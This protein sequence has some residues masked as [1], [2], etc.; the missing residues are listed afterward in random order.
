MKRLFC[1]L[2]ALAMGTEVLPLRGMA[3]AD[4]LLRFQ[5]D[6]TSG[7][8]I[9]TASYQG[10]DYVMGGARE[11]GGYLALTAARSFTT[12]LYPGEEYESHDSYVELWA[13]QGPNLFQV[14]EGEDFTFCLQAENGLWLK[15][16]D[17]TLRCTEIGEAPFFWES[18]YFVDDS[19]VSALNVDKALFLV[20]HVGEGTPYFT[21]ADALG[22]ADL[23]C[24]LAAQTECS[25][26]N[27]MTHHA[28]VAPTCVKSGSLEYW[29]CS[30][31]E[32]AGRAYRFYDEE[33][34]NPFWDDSEIVLPATGHIDD[35]AD[36]VCDVCGNGM[37]VFTRVTL[38]SQIQAGQTYLLA[39]EV[40]ES[41]YLLARPDENDLYSTTMRATESVTPDKDGALRYSD[42]RSA[43]ALMFRLDISGGKGGKS[44]DPNLIG[45][46]NL[47]G[48]ISDDG[49]LE[50]DAGYGF[51]YNMGSGYG[52]R[53][54]LDAPPTPTLLIPR[55]MSDFGPQFY[56]RAFAPE[57]APFFSTLP[58]YDEDGE[59]LELDP[60]T[61]EYPV[62]LY[63]LNAEEVDSWDYG[64]V[65]QGETELDFSAV[66]DKPGYSAEIAAQSSVTGLA[67]AVTDGT[68]RAKIEDFREKTGSTASN[69]TLTA[70][71][72][73]TADGFEASNAATGKTLRYSISHHLRVEDNSAEPITY[74]L[75]PG[76]LQDDGVCY[77]LVL[78]SWYD[79]AQVM[80]TDEFIMGGS[81][82]LTHGETYYRKTSDPFFGEG[83]LT[84]AS[85]T[86]ADGQNAL[87]CPVLPVAVQLNETAVVEPHEHCTD[88]SDEERDAHYV[89]RQDGHY[90]EC[91][92]CDEPQFIHPHFYNLTDCDY[93]FTDTN[94]GEYVYHCSFCYER[95]PEFYEKRETIDTADW[96]WVNIVDQNGAPVPQFLSKK[97]YCYD[98]R[99]KNDV[100]VIYSVEWFKGTQHL[101]EKDVAD[102]EYADGCAALH[103]R[104]DVLSEEVAAAPLN[105]VIS[106]TSEAQLL[107]KVDSQLRFDDVTL[108][109]AIHVDVTKRSGRAITITGRLPEEMTDWEHIN[110]TL[111]TT[112]PELTYY[113]D[114]QFEDDGSFTITAP[115]AYSELTISCTTPIN[116]I[117]VNRFLFL[118]NA[119]SLGGYGSESKLI[120]LGVLDFANHNV[121]SS[122]SFTVEDEVAALVARSAYLGG[123]YSLTNE[124]TGE[125]WTSVRKSCP[126]GQD[127][128]AE[129]GAF[130]F[131]LSLEGDYAD[132]FAVG[133]TVVL[134]C[135]LRDRAYRMDPFRFTLEEIGNGEGNQDIGTPDFYRLPMLYIDKSSVDRVLQVRYLWWSLLFDGEGRLLGDQYLANSYCLE[136]GSYTY[137]AYA[138][139]RFIDLVDSPNALEMMRVPTTGYYRQTFTVRRNDIVTVTPQFTDIDPYQNVTVT[140]TL[141]E[142]LRTGESVPVYISY[143]GFDADYV[144]LVGSYAMTVTVRSHTVNEY[145][146]RCPLVRVGGC[147]AT[148]NNAAPLSETELDYAKGGYHYR[149]VAITANAT[150]GTICVY[151]RPDGNSLYITAESSAANTDYNSHSAFVL[152]I[153]ANDV[154][155]QAPPAFTS[156]PDGEL[157]FL[158]SLPRDGT[159][160]VA[161]AFVDGQETDAKTVN[162]AGLGV[163]TLHYTLGH[164]GV[165]THYHDLRLEIYTA[166]CDESGNWLPD[167]LACLW[168][169]QTYYVAVNV[170]TAVPQPS[171]LTV[172]TRLGDGSNLQTRIDLKSS[173]NRQHSITFYPQQF[174]EDGTLNE[175]L[176]YD[177]RLALD[178]AHNLAEGE[179][180]VLMTVYCGEQHAEPTLYQV[181]LL[182]NEN[183]GT[184]DGTLH[185]DADTIRLDDLPF[186]YSFFF[187]GP[188]PEQDSSSA[189]AQAAEAIERRAQSLTVDEPLPVP[190]L[191]DLDA[192]ETLLASDPDMEEWEKEIMRLDA[193]YQNNLHDCWLELQEFTAAL[194]AEC[195]SRFDTLPDFS[196]SGTT[197]G[198]ELLGSTV[199]EVT[200]AELGYQKAETPS[201][202]YY[203]LLDI[204]KGRQSVVE[205]SS[206]PSR[207]IH[208]WSGTSP[209][210][211]GTPLARGNAAETSEALRTAS[212]TLLFSSA[213]DVDEAE[214]ELASYYEADFV[215]AV[216]SFL[217][218]RNDTLEKL[219]TIVFKITDPAVV[220]SQNASGAK[221]EALG[222][223]VEA[224]EAEMKRK[225]M[226]LLDLDRE[227]A[228]TKEKFYQKYPTWRPS[229]KTAIVP[230]VEAENA[231]SDYVKARARVFEQLGEARKVEAS[232]RADQVTIG[233]LKNSEAL[234]TRINEILKAGSEVKKDLKTLAKAA[235]PY[236]ATGLSAVCMVL[237]VESYLNAH[238]DTQIA[239]RAGAANR[240]V[241]DEMRQ[242]MEDALQDPC[243]KH[244]WLA[245]L[246]YDDC[247][248]AYEDYCAASFR[249][250]HASYIRTACM[251][252]MIIADIIAL[253]AAIGNAPS[254]TAAGAFVVV[255]NSL[256]LTATTAY[257]AWRWSR[258]QKA[259]NELNEEC[260]E[261]LPFSRD[262]D[263]DSPPKE[264]APKSV[265]PPK[266][267]A[268]TL[269]KIDPSGYAY[270][271]VASNRLSGVTATIWYRDGSGNAQP[272]EDAPYYEEVYRQTT[273]ADGR[274]EWMTPPGSW[275][276]K[277]SK[278]GYEDADSRQ[279]P[280]AD[281]EGWLPV[282]PPQLNVNIPMVSKAAP[283]VQSAAVSSDRVRV[284]FS[285]YMQESAAAAVTV[286][287]N[288]VPLELAAAFVDREE[289]P[290]QAGVFYG[291]VLE[292]AGSFAGEGF[293]V[294]VDTGAKNYAGT[295]LAS[296]YSSG[297][298]SVTQVVGTLSHVYPNRFVTDVSDTEELV[299]TVLDTAGQPMPDVPVAVSQQRDDTL[300]F[301]A[302]TAVSDAS[303]RAV[304]SVKGIASGYNT[305]TFSAGPASVQMNTRVKP[306]GTESPKKPTANLSDGQTVPFGTPLT[307]QCATEDAVIFY[308]T[309]NTCPCTEDG[310]RRTYTQPISLTES[311]LLRI[312]SYTES[313][314]YSERLNLRINVHVPVTQSDDGLTFHD[315]PEGVFPV[316]GYYSA[317][318]QLIDVK[319]TE[320][321]R[322]SWDTAPGDVRVFFLDGNCLPVYPM[323]RSNGG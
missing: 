91:C 207:R 124:R 270:E 29:V 215:P 233:K 41:L 61:V 192:L 60:Q 292:L 185:F 243:L 21:V 54:R 36:G 165:G 52:W 220:V 321:E 231:T 298:L 67:A 273:G 248:E 37:P 247:V 316:V 282:P 308:T 82:E 249:Y 242:Q 151:A 62:Y 70:Y 18:G 180:K 160:Y 77:D 99:G 31:C 250:Q 134:N 190:E 289:S 223:E 279:D 127:P 199:T 108:G 302:G 25:H 218:L 115:Y 159:T 154:T 163:N 306:L 264:P 123:S 101:G 204:A 110:G 315:L 234:W 235:G 277:L 293:T 145:D 307:L 23:P 162:L 209:L 42:V 301:S 283:T 46:D 320:G 300:R 132:H 174:N 150:E 114:L 19:W 268:P 170:N 30:Q 100:V 284:V 195:C 182:R 6:R 97:D 93:S 120:D 194:S 79:P 232:L 109:Q 96:A 251:Y 74:L 56:M 139:N 39:T 221:V 10:N 86:H 38:D 73:L 122:F 85:F 295:P 48:L 130:T 157:V 285:Q 116:G 217:S 12:V 197:G 2:L 228:A 206:D 128:H 142:N 237:D 133:D 269:P 44:E 148:W 230:A 92:R 211:V 176:T 119:Q 135:S 256:T 281:A 226:S 138:K 203:I 260:I 143:K 50:Y 312:A 49:E 146:A 229:K 167:S 319:R 287:K 309:D 278:E 83:R 51:Y 35:D 323:W 200:L 69:Y 205:W 241:M 136:E 219:A 246:Q 140:A 107:Y 66:A 181:T 24:Q 227:I 161:K 55:M 259:E 184:F 71:S 275:L 253:A 318:G 90:L 178:N 111:T 16:A 94:V 225:N 189:T 236:L 4:V 179:N 254:A 7:P 53:V 169:S 272:W 149:G 58:A 84:T 20:L 196:G 113:H 89:C 81:D 317:S 64:T 13:G 224:L 187:S 9:V 322:V 17:N 144:D 117:N 112:F 155:V 222:K 258:L 78:Y 202:D 45:A 125:V 153:P 238:E 65:L 126:E 201:G 261:P 240:K 152:T 88:W 95:G 262:S 129:S 103:Y 14:S 208:R 294:S 216:L 47:Y 173:K 156:D 22:E 288:G 141:G 263:C 267:P 158:A 27:T 166:D 212:S 40:N 172:S 305:L 57:E 98:Y 214:A 280:A 193:N 171:V 314:G 244:P 118:R 210:P 183:T 34:T 80:L 255:S 198:T 121:C 191:V 286:A 1:L 271:A 291:R 311:T 276:V 310:S 265:D 5:K 303:G 297:A 168:R 28:A 72:R 11:G 59:N 274:Y 3:A 290:T 63:L 106:F 105:C 8:V 131:E 252:L 104:E 313:G 239:Y 304:F 257:L 76:E 177:Y 245:G 188:E 186:G 213:S 43:D 296:A 175:E 75:T 266:Y 137:L 26:H 32:A 33:G 102:P 87:S 15:G 147:Y 164:P 68:A 299:V